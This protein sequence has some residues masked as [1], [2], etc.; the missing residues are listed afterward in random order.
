MIERGI[1]QDRI[2]LL[3]SLVTA[4]ALVFAL[5]LVNL[6]IL[7]HAHYREIAERNRTQILSQAAP[8][9]RIYTRDSAAVA[10]N[11]PSFSLIYFPGE[12]KSAEAMDGMAR[13]LSHYLNIP[14][15][16]LQANLYRAVK[17]GAPMRLAE[18]LS[19]KAMFSLSELKTMYSGIDIIVEARRYYPF[20]NYLSHLTGYISKMDAKEW[21]VYGKD[22]NYAMDSRI[23]K[24][25]LEKMYERD[26]KG[27]DGGIYLEVDSRGRL[28]KI[29]ESRKWETGAD[30][31]LTIDSKIQSAAE[32]GLKKSNTGKGAVVA[33]DPRSGAI[34]ALASM[35]DYDPNRF[36][37]YSDQKSSDSMKALP[38][39]NVAVQG[40]YPPASTFKILSSIAALES[41]RVSPA[42]TFFCPGYYDAGSRVFK[43]WEK[44]GHGK[45]DLIQG[46]AK[47]CDVYYYN[48][49]IRT[50]ALNIEKYARLF[51]LG[52]PTGI[53]LPDEKSGN[54]FGPSKRAA[55]KSYW[56]IGD[57]LNLAIGQGETLV[58][59]IQM[60]QVAAVIANGGIF[61]RPYYVDHIV[62]NEGQISF[63][64]KPEK[65][66]QIQ[67]K[68]S[69]RAI[70]KEGLREVILSGT[71]QSTKIEGV[72]VFGKT[73]TAQNP[74]GRD[75]AWFVAFAQLP[76]G[77]AE[78][79][80]AVLVEHGLH[81][82]STAGP[83][84]R[85]VVL[86][87]MNGRLP[88]RRVM[89]KTLPAAG[90]EAVAG[91]TMPPA[92]VEEDER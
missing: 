61:W 18:N 44:K 31:Y 69:T 9:G 76:N 51:R 1:S 20:G 19:S 32:E 30:I 89:V 54:I 28:S 27:K 13:S 29:L 55:N 6:Q 23:G 83:I 73:G 72:E 43:C 57:T 11:K 91:S 62:N 15:D 3:W 7:M 79:A 48:L 74:Q 38:E 35:P 87:A 60:A 90:L 53:P 16:D 40:V 82:A 2:N 64:G 56:F 84:V 10:T 22:K 39:F 77:P 24:A 75:H 25:G 78:I 37:S 85:D 58:T 17:K 46:L 5:R 65:I 26:L 81:G 52:V 70:L 50:G 14:F 88:E 59:P 68:E 71:G 34:L 67:L 45:V 4:V 42:E 41:G 36:V 63:R 66:S 21:A 80:V 49:G 8:R 47:S 33:I 86:A 92:A 12:M